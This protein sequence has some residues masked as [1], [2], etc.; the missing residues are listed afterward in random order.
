MKT[1]K[2]LAL[3]AFALLFSQC[4]ST[5][6][7]APSGPAPSLFEVAQ[8]LDSTE[9]KFLA[10]TELNNGNANQSIMQTLSWVQSQPNVQSAA[11]LDSTYITII[12]KSGLRTT[13]Y[14]DEVGAD[15]MS[16][17]RGGGG[18]GSSKEPALSGSGILSKNT[19][20]NKNVLVYCAGYSNFYL[21]NG[22]IQVPINILNRSGAGL[23]VTLLEDEQCTY[24][25]VDHFKDYGLV[26]IDT[27][28]FPDGFMIGTKITVDATITTND[29][30]TAS[31]AKQGGQ[32]MLDKLLSGE[33]SFYHHVK[34]GILRPYWWRNKNGSTFELDLFMTSKYIDALPAMPGTV[35]FGNMCYSGWQNNLGTGYN[36]IEL[37]FINKNPIS[38][39]CFAFLNGT[40]APVSDAFAKIMEDS[41]ADA[42]AIDLD[43]TKT[44]NLMPSD[45][46]T[47]YTDPYFTTGQLHFKH[48]GYDD[49][50]YPVPCGDT[51]ID[52]RDGQRYATV[53][54]GNQ[55]WMAQN[56]NYDVPGALCYNGDPANCAAYGKLYDFTTLTQGPVSSTKVPSG[57]QGVCPKGW[58]VPS[59]SEFIVMIKFLGGNGFGGGQ[60]AGAMKSTSSLWN[61]PNTGAT[62]SS[63][64]SALPGGDGVIGGSFY[65]NIG[66]LAEFNTSTA[67]IAPTYIAPSVYTLS[68]N[69][70]GIQPG[71]LGDGARSCRCVKDP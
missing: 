9:S 64:F 26:I 34:G 2:L 70:N 36:P 11:A 15:S 27:H 33:L 55:K 63:G 3:A 23:N 43:S 25:I 60:V 13:F 30:F 58:H 57:V 38:Y 69:S 18:S 16:I 71:V 53:C 67:T 61:S 35:I 5:A 59:D 42:L 22:S 7:T 19:I 29:L 62:N 51:L 44:A 41:L 14:F 52:S 8:I 54:I 1:L 20:T 32:D 28:G 6:P 45:H 65:Q 66:I 12:L 40:S 39:Y 56:L 31:I 50:S 10:Y 4:K 48:F 21:S 47:E 68:N 17:F 24:Q 46:Q 37:S 49:Y